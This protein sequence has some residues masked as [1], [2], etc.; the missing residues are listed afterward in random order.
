ME[1]GSGIRR[2]RS[3]Y[4]EYLEKRIAPAT[5]VV[6]NLNDSGAGSLR[7]AVDRANAAPGA[8]K[9]VFKG[10]ATEGEITLTSGEIDITGSVDI[11]GPGA[12]RLIIDAQDLFRIFDIGD[13]TDA[14][15]KVTI[16][17]LSMVAGNSA[18]D[19]GT[20]GG[21]ILTTE[22][23]TLIN[24]VISGC[25]APGGPGG[26]IYASTPGKVVIKNSKITG[27]TA[28]TDGAGLWLQA[29]SGVKVMNSLVSGNYAESNGAGV[30]VHINATGTGDILLK[31]ARIT[32]NTAGVDGG[33]ALLFNDRENASGAKVGKITVRNS[34][35]TGNDAEGGGGIFLQGGRALIERSTISNNVAVEHGGGIYDQGLA[36][37]TIRK[38]QVVDNLAAAYFETAGGGGI[39]I[40]NDQNVTIQRTLIAGNTAISNGGGILATLSSIQILD[41]TISENSA[42]T[43]G[44]GVSTRSIALGGTDIRVVDSLFSSNRA[45]NSGGGLDTRGGGDVEISNSRFLYNS[46]A[47]NGGGLYLRTV[48]GNISITNSL[49]SENT[50]GEDGG[51]L[52]LQWEP[53]VAVSVTKTAI[54]NNVA[55]GDDGGGVAIANPTGAIEFKASTVTGNVAANQ[56]GGIYTSGA[57]INLKRT[58]VADNTAPIDPQIAMPLIV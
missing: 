33:G 38:S 58:P 55:A 19:T 37:L 16:S 26:G 21:G 53:G 23:L 11:K 9:I 20:P 6:T 35:V 17:G 39:Y 29:D 36:S 2:P 45:G 34:L 4:I 7:D 40:V 3:V 49:I 48:S 32:S 31:N 28:G 43:D 8:D 5:F 12:G 44:G 25:Q 1:T 10:D 24:S 42:G 13:G 57:R 22:S 52:A 50:A 14:V 56:G 46:A 51:G 41:S 30:Y 18:T 54:T 15:K 27:N 47:T